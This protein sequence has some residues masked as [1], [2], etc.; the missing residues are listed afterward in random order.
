[1]NIDDARSWFNKYG[2]AWENRD[3]EQFASLFAT[4]AVYHWDPIDREFRGREE[5]KA[6]FESAIS[7]QKD[8]HFSYEI[9]S[10]EENN[11][12]AHWKC[13]LTRTTSGRKVQ[14]DGIMVVKFDDSGLCTIFKE[15]W[16]SNE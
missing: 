12:I 6:A 1:M 5:I 13:E 14:I 2:S 8:I 4:E 7:T 9:M 16:H 10:S 3:P 15:W 11:S